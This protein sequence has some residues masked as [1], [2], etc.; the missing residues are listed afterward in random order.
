MS[1]LNTALWIVGSYLVVI[2]L[3]YSI[4]NFLTKGFIRQY[5]KAKMSRGK[6]ILVECNDV[7]DSY[8]KTGKIDTKRALLVK[9]N[10][11]KVHTF[12]GITLN[13]VKRKLGVNIIEVD[14]VKGLLIKKDYSGATAY[15]LTICD[16]MIN[17]GLMLPKLNNDDIWVIILKILAVLTFLGVLV[18]IY[19]VATIEPNCPIIDTAVNII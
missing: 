19:L 2:I 15:D 17:R 16:D 9:D 11:K 6:L 12:A 7:T 1:G 13:D 8:Y 10:L 4:M 14:L 5:L 18:L 3:G